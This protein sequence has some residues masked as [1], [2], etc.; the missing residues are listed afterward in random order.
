MLVSSKLVLVDDLVAIGYPSSANIVSSSVVDFGDVGDL[1]EGHLD[2]SWF[3]HLTI[4]QE[5]NEGLHFKVDILEERRSLDI[6][7]LRHLLRRLLLV[8]ELLQEPYHLTHTEL[9]ASLKRV[10]IQPLRRF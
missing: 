6:A 8:S 7:S 9:L 4:P 3:I 10:C 1:L 5:H 2:L